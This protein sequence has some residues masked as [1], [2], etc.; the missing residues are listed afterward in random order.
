MT[1][2]AVPTEFYFDV[3]VYDCPCGHMYGSH[4][5][6]YDRGLMI[7]MKCQDCPQPEPQQPPEDA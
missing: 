7:I 1:S 2:C 3:D 5:Y 4:E 6:K